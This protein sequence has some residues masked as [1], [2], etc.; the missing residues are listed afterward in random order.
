MALSGA[1]IF[2]YNIQAATLEKVFKRAPKIVGPIIR[3]QVFRI[4][5]GFRKRWL[6]AEDVDFRGAAKRNFPLLGKSPTSFP[7]GAD[8]GTAKRIFFV[9][10]PP[11]GAPIKKLGQ[12]GAD[13]F[14]VSKVWKKLEE[15]GTEKPKSGSKLALPIGV[16]LDSR[17]RVKSRWNTPERFT[18]EKKRGARNVLV[19]IFNPTSGNTILYWQQPHGA[20]K[21]K[22]YS[23]RPAFLLVDQVDQRELLHFYETWTSEA[24]NRVKI[25]RTMMAKIV[26]AVADG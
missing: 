16:T 7:S 14:S 19:A 3:D 15:G 8:G 25:L 18:R 1:G 11:K 4:V 24:P 22:R 17:G 10:T 12:I 23:Y 26:K 2:S 20:G 5:A 9:T 13:I 6:Q 21:N